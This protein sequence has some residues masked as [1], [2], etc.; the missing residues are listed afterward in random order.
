[1][2]LVPLAW[3]TGLLLALMTHPG[4]TQPERGPFLAAS[5]PPADALRF[6][7]LF[8]GCWMLD[9][10]GREAT[11]AGAPVAEGVHSS[12]GQSE[13]RDGAPSQQDE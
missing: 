6:F 11:W 10:G 9:L 5:D 8:W 12:F 13:T 7:Y 2:K 4:D 3:C 1:M